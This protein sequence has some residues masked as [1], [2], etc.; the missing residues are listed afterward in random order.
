MILGIV[1]IDKKQHSAGSQ[2]TIILPFHT[3]WVKGFVFSNPDYISN[4]AP[5]TVN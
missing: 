4:D 1:S 2:Y 5:K 3:N